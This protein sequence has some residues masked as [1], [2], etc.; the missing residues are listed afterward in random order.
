MLAVKGQ[1]TYTEAG[2]NKE[3]VTVLV[4]TR[5]DGRVTTSVIVYPYKRQIPKNIIDSLPAGVCPARSASGW[6]TSDIFFEFFANTFIPE[7]A[8]TRRREKGLTAEEPLEL[9][10]ADWVVYWMDGYKSHL[11]IHL[12]KLCELNKILLYCFKAHSSHIC[13]PNDVGPFKPLKAEWRLAVDEWRLKHPYAVLTRQNFAE[14]FM[15]ALN[16]L[17]PEAIKAGYRSTG[18]YPFDVCAVHFDRITATNQEVFDK[19]A[20]EE[21]PD[22]Q[23]G[24]RCLETVLGDSIVSRY[25]EAA[26]Q[27]IVLLSDLP[28]V[29]TYLLWRHFLSVVNGA[30]TTMQMEPSTVT[31]SVDD[32]TMQLLDMACQPATSSQN[33]N[34]NELTLV[35]D[36]ETSECDARSV[37]ATIHQPTVPHLAEQDLAG[38]QHLQTFSAFHL[39]TPGKVIGKFQNSFY[40]V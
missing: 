32:L 24:L 17:N 27:N 26:E 33:I 28:D 38:V 36:L 14:V 7:L 40:A 8:E 3:Q 21:K 29:N 19:Q 23:V 11:T 1:S 35:A 5:A 10:D 34:G 9:T 37:P 13:Q 4:T 39:P 6:M 22:F 31:L 16:K 12:S 18:L 25:R 30:E 15:K 2:G 20:F